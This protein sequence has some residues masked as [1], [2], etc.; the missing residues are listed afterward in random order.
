M[1]WDL[2]VNLFTKVAVEQ[3]SQTPKHSM[4][5]VGVVYLV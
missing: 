4:F 3:S 2:P 1:T 5:A